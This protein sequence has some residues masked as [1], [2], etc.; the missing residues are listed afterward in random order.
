[1]SLP[2]CMGCLRKRNL[3]QIIFH[4]FLGVEGLIDGV[5]RELEEHGTEGRLFFRRVLLEV[6]ELDRKEL[7]LAVCFLLQDQGGLLLVEALLAQALARHATPGLTM[8]TYAR[9]R[10][11]RLRELSER[12]GQ[13]VDLV[14]KNRGFCAAG[15]LQK[16]ASLTS[17]GKI[18]GFM[19][20]DTGFEAPR[21]DE[22]KPNKTLTT[23]SQNPALARGCEASPHEPDCKTPA[24]PG[25]NNSTILPPKCATGVLVPDLDTWLDTC[26]VKLPEAARIRISAVARVA[27][28][29]RW[30]R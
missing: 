17:A 4:L 20:G 12:M 10:S 3:T 13:G 30:S 8:N 22:Q 5:A 14:A 25:H 28:R 24:S 15:V 19:E 18:E 16:L 2:S 9:T 23:S 11:E 7:A 21:A 27:K 29:K 6:R 1:M 26:P